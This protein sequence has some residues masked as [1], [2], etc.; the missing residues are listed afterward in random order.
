M[1]TLRQRLTIFVL[2]RLSR[3][4]NLRCLLTKSGD[5]SQ[6]SKA[7]PPTCEGLEIVA[8][9]KCPLKETSKQKMIVKA[10]KKFS[11]DLMR[12]RYVTVLCVAVQGLILYDCLPASA[13]LQL[14]FPSRQRTSFIVE[15]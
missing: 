1:P 6:H 15:P 3:L 11:A 8:E 7:R 10:A 14:G 5:S 12:W 2:L 9:V 13:I 4:F